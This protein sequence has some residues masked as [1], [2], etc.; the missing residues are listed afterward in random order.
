MT[1]EQTDMG[2]VAYEAYYQACD[3]R[4]VH[5][6]QLPS[7]TGQAPAIRENWRA[8]A[9]A[10]LILADLHA[11]HMSVLCRVRSGQ[12]HK[13]CSGTCDAHCD[14]RCHKGGQ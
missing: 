7:W 1:T 2:R 8:A 9:D 3:G 11:V 10:V 6:E 5:G 14:C 12:E 4:S 13:P